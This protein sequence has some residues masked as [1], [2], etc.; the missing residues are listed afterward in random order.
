MIT[1]R[2]KDDWP[3]A[4]ERFER[5]WLCEKTDRPLLRVTARR[6]KQLGDTPAPEDPGPPHKYLDLDYIIQRV[7]H[8]FETT[9]FGGDAFP[10]ADAN[11]GP[12]SL[13]LYLGSEPGFAESTVWFKPCVD[14]LHD[15]PLPEFDPENEWLVTHLGLI[16]GLREAFADDAWVT[17]PDLVESLDILAALRD[18]MHFL[19]DLMDCPD[20]V[21]RWLARIN[22][23]YLP[24]Y[25]RFYDIVRHDDGSS[26]FTA[27]QIWGPGKTAKVQCDFAAMISPDQFAEFYAPYVAA[28]VDQLAR[29]L[30]HLDGPDCICHVPHLLAV[31]NL[32]AIQWTCGAGNPPGGDETWYPLYEQILGGGKG[33]QVSMD[34]DAVEP[35]LKRFGPDGVYILTNVKTQ[36]EADELVAMTTRVCGR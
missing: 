4:A 8:S 23:L 27:F 30:Y 1:S 9:Y 20:D 5:W 28:Q 15:T 35:F 26:A 6:D 14:S 19:Y 18:P 3:D 34:A 25:D 31:E 32:N 10:S 12:G 16:R 22:D 29:S 7:R 33:L 24:C 11:L 13:A 21:H 36:R 2:Y 17:V